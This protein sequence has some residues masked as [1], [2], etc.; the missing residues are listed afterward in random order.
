MTSFLSVEFRTLLRS[1]IAN[2]EQ[3]PTI[4]IFEDE[5]HHYFLATDLDEIKTAILNLI[6]DL[7]RNT[8]TSIVF[9]VDIL[10][11]TQLDALSFL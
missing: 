1:Q 9:A 10:P 7:D 6:P 11:G 8:L 5:Q 3:F 2:P 4:T